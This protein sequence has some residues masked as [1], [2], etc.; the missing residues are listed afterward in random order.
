MRFC[1]SLPLLIDQARE[2]SAKSR[3]VT[4]QSCALLSPEFFACPYTIEVSQLTYL[5]RH[6]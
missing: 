4:F 5:G 1:E 2:S 6:K 3:D